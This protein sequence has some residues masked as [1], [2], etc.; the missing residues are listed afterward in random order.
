MR[1]QLRDY[2]QRGV[3]DLRGAYREG[4]RAPLLSS[5]TGSGKTVMFSHIA[6]QADSRG[7]AV[8]VLVHR[9]ELLAQTSKALNEIGVRHQL[10]APHQTVH[11]VRAEQ[12]RTTGSSTIDQTSRLQVASV[13]TLVR[14]LDKTPP[15]DLIVID[16]CH[17]AVAGSWHRVIQA[18]PNARLLGVTATPHRLDGKGLGVEAGGPFDTLVQGPT[19]RELIDAGYL[20][21]PVVYAPPM[22]ASLEGVHM[23]GGDYA[24]NELA[25][26]LDKPRITGDA[27]DHYRRICDGAPAIA[28]CANVKHAQHVAEQFRQAGYRWQCVDGTMSTSARDRAIRGL[29][30]G[31]LHGISSCEIVNEGT[32]VPIVAA[33]I[34]LRATKSL[35]L[36]LQ[37]CGRILRPYPGK[38][39]A[40]ILDHVG[41]SLVHGLPDWDRE[42]SLAGEEK[43]KRGSK[44]PPAPPVA[45]CPQCYAAHAPAPQCPVCGYAYAEGQS[46]PEQQDGELTEVTPE[47]A[48]AMRRQARR[49]VGRAQ[50]LED[51]KRIEAARG[52]KPGWAD[53]V[54]AARK[55]K[56]RAA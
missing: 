37:Q 10:I 56:R 44:A 17:H 53:H 33:G 40:I 49:E 46:M 9:R 45:Q 15:P 47:Q 51:L 39:R 12:L 16:E 24:S 32:D 31:T 1:F 48:E 23:R 21:Q 7:N 6:E 36:H 26:R 30:D 25:E 3:D 27:I 8:M 11:D 41:N 54:W 14:R 20:C 38:D 4:F 43:K 50:T 13:Q 52:Y 22:Q 5:P 28:F 55:R 2:Q 18:F 35:G 34:L 19:V 42:W 29:G